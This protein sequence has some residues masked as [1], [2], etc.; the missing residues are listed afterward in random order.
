MHQFYLYDQN[1]LVF[2]YD[3]YQ[4]SCYRLLDFQKQIG[5]KDLFIVLKMGQKHNVRN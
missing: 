1:I 4:Q 2:D 3:Y 5:L